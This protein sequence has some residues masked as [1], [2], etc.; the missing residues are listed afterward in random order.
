MTIG[1][2]NHKVDT[3]M[4]VYYGYISLIVMDNDYIMDNDY[5]ISYGT[6][7]IDNVYMLV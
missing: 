3:N 7:S 1:Y 2:E 5:H 4:L 6:S